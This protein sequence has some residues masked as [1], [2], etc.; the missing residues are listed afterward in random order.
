MG[1]KLTLAMASRDQPSAFQ[2]YGLTSTQTP[3]V[4]QFR[5]SSITRR[6]SDTIVQSVP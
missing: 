5:L 4:S 2:R 6:Y 3:V 1:G